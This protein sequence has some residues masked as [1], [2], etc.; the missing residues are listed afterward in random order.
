MACFGL[1]STDSAQTSK[2]GV[3]TGTGRDQATARVQ[4]VQ[5]AA[6]L[7]RE[8]EASSL[9][10]SRDA[11]PASALARPASAGKVCVRDVFAMYP[12]MKIISDIPKQH[13]PRCQSTPICWRQT[14]EMVR[15]PWVTP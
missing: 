12:I 4:T 6:A 8:R 1:R 9:G 14:Q 13:L 15:N 2:P 11:R 7:R 5:R 10:P 3:L